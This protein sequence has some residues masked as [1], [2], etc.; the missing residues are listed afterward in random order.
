MR[1]S[2]AFS[3][4]NSIRTGC[5]F[6]GW[7]LY[8]GGVNQFGN[9]FVFFVAIKVIDV[10]SGL[11]WSGLVSAKKN[12]SKNESKNINFFSNGNVGDSHRWL[13]FSIKE[14]K[15]KSLFY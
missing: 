10:A 4:Q 12:E 7:F 11:E 14:N 9:A 3:G 2:M 15:D 1:E 13:Y 5:S 8:Q 6:R